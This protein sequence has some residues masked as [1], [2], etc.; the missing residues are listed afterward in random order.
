MPEDRDSIDQYL[1]E[2]GRY[3]LLTVEEEN[4]LGARSHAGDEHAVAELVNRN[5]RFVISVAKKYQNRG[6]PLGDLI[7]EGNVGLLTAARKFDPAQGV[8]FVSYA[9]WWIRQAILSAV[10][11]QMSM[12]RIPS[13]RAAEFARINR[14]ADALRQELQSEPSLAEI[15]EACG[16]PLETVRAVGAHSVRDVSFDEPLK[17][18]GE[19]TLLDHCS[20]EEAMDSGDEETGSLISL[21]LAK[22]LSLLPERNARI[23]RLHF[24][25]EGGHEH[26]LEEIGALLGVT[27]ERVRQLRDRALRRIR[28]GEMA[29]EL[30]DLAGAKTITVH[31]SVS[32]VVLRPL[33]VRRRRAARLPRLLDGILQ[34]AAAS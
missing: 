22:A 28:E 8:R 4:E 24:G 15:A 30:G 1:R 5:L 20:T 33:P 12:V 2:V 21:K 10:S 27:R 32:V 13:S 29:R 31:P 25:L 16:V 18:D 23:L 17:H 9:V 19:Q 7:G 3:A 6:L 11:R 34:R 26:T 14:T